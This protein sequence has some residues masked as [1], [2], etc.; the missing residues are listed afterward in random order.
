MVE[1]M[2]AVVLVA[3]GLGNIFAITTQSLHALRTTRQVGG[4]SRVLQQR[5][6]MIRGKAWPEIANATA[7]AALMQVPAESEKELADADLVETVVV[8]VPPLPGS[9]TPSTTASFTVER[10]AGD[11]AILA[12]AD[13]GDEQVLV[14]EVTAGWRNLRGPQQRQLRTL[15]CRSGL[16]RSGV[17]GSALGKSSP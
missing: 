2:V 5:V 3:L 14:V 6:E 11:G 8:S 4:A 12:N 13:L 9:S 15:I 16:T 7:L 1:V 17:F 10:R